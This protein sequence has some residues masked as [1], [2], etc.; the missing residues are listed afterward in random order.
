MA[1]N[2][3]LLQ[4]GYSRMTARSVCFAF[5]LT[6]LVVAPAAALNP[7]RRITRYILD[8]YGLE[9]GLPQN[10]VNSVIQTR[11]GYLWVGTQEGLARFDGVNFELFTTKNTPV[12]TSNFIQVL[13]QDRE[14]RL[15]VGTNGGG[16]YLKDRK[17]WRRYDQKQGLGSSVVMAFCQDHQGR[18]WLGAEDGLYYLEGE[19]FLRK[20]LS[21]GEKTFGVRAL[22]ADPMGGLWVGTYGQGLYY[23]QGDKIFRHDRTQGLV[24]D[25]IISLLKDASGRIWAGTYSSGLFYLDGDRWRQAWSDSGQET[26]RIMA[27][28]RDRQG[29]LWLGTY[30]GGLA[31]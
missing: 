3:K 5:L 19:R 31:R 22:L 18:I 20:E 30:G 1:K 2:E 21:V 10:T 23:I 8:A 25:V 14:E 17:G 4:P 15:W 16:V 7:D 11:D 29:S 13:F 9:R 12:F 27:L 28:H 26:N 6:W 24:D